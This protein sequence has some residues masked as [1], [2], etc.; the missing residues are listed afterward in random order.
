MK[1]TIKITEGN[2]FAIRFR[3][4]KGLYQSDAPIDEDIDYS[5]LENVAVLVGNVVWS[6]HIVDANG[7]VVHIPATQA[8]GTYNVEIT[9]EYM[10][11]HIRAA[12]FEC[13]QIVAWSYQSDAQNYI[14]D[15]TEE[16]QV[17][18]VISEYASDAELER[19]KA[20]YRAWTAAAEQAKRAADAA[21]AA[22]EQAAL[23]LQDV[24]QQTTLTAGITSLL[25]AL[26]QKADEGTLT[27]AEQHILTA[28][29]G[30]DLSGV[31]Q[32]STLQNV[33]TTLAGMIGPKATS[34][35]VTDAVSTLRTILLGK[36]N[37][38]TVT[39]GFTA[40][41]S[42]LSYIVGLINTLQGYAQ[43]T[44]AKE[45]TLSGGISTL[46]MAI[47]GIKPEMPQVVVGNDTAAVELQP[48]TLYIFTNR[49]NNLAIT[50]VP[51]TAGIAE[52]YHMFVEVGET[53]PT[54]T[55]PQSV[56]W[57]V[58]PGFT[59]YEKTEISILNNSGIW[60]Q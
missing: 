25:E 41:G 60:V 50:L 9:A 18:Y 43:T 15:G 51:G 48:N 11:A 7:V 16:A 58:S 40:Q 12:Y 49:T 29:A 45:N 6:D 30:I 22:F 44:L 46:S 13:F 33:A 28:I 4:I 47:A 21:K 38:Q 17:V 24:A 39:Y 37:E 36:A 35:D 34:Q 42:T 20:E 2:E 14:P 32:E 19:I 57:L 52:E 1:Y 27:A 56:E 31:A 59:P 53:V 3:F 5:E 8:R 54:V 10:G 55:F 26:A 23:E